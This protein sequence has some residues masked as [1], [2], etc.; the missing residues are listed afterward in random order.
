MLLFDQLLGSGSVTSGQQYVVA[1]GAL[2]AADS[3]PVT[4]VVDSPLITPNTFTRSYVTSS[5]SL[6]SVTWA[7]SVNLFVAVGNLGT[8]LTSADGQIW[9]RRTSPSNSY[10]RNVSWNYGSNKIIATGTANTI[11]YSTDAVNWTVMPSGSI[12][13]GE[14]IH[15]SVGFNDGNGYGP[16]HMFFTSGGGYYT[17]TATSTWTFTKNTTIPSNIVSVSSERNSGHNY[18]VGLDSTFSQNRFGN[19]SQTS[20]RTMYVNYGTY[21]STWST[22]GLTVSTNNSYYGIETYGDVGY[23]SL[24]SNNGFIVVGF[25]CSVPGSATSNHSSSM[26]TGRISSV[27]IDSIILQTNSASGSRAYPANGTQQQVSAICWHPQGEFYCAGYNGIYASVSG[28]GGVLGSNSNY[29]TNANNFYY[30]KNYVNTDTGVRAAN[31]V[32]N[33]DLASIATD[34][35]LTNTSAVVAVGNNGL[36]VSALANNTSTTEMY[37]RVPNQNAASETTCG[38]YNSGNYIAGS[39]N[40]KIYYN[41][42]PLNDLIFVTKINEANLVSMCYGGK[43]YALGGTAGSL[44]SSADFTT[45]TSEGSAGFAL[46]SIT[47]W[48]GTTYYYAVGAGGK[49][50]KYNYSGSANFVAKTSG[51]TTNLN[52]VAGNSS[53]GLV[54]VGSSN[55]FIYSADGETFYTKALG[56][57]FSTANITSVAYGYS[58]N[59][60]AYI[61]TFV[62]AGGKMGYINASDLTNNPVQT[63]TTGTSND[64][65]SVSYLNG[66]TSGNCWFAVG[67]SGTY[68]YSTDGV[69]WTLTTMGSTDLNIV[70]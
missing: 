48:D 55:T 13:S 59:L 9:K 17:N 32:V 42:N 53:I 50:Y 43:Y 67:K 49:I 22:I 24:S 40:G 3:E 46:S 23:N 1:G 4:Y 15:C 61:Y 56:A 44:Y 45:W 47:P 62:G 35:K 36:I 14:I 28:A 39:R 26:V 66:G 30:Y 37:T 12:G 25:Q 5:Q 60:S 34:R 54:A 51:V 21:T 70:Y 41:T 29:Y 19:N 16:M 38:L 68:M 65:L 27:G 57:N 58:S 18:I 33:Y 6:T 20:A 8:I 11:V 7:N 63:I 10:F 64:L 31:G 69:N 2:T 52:K